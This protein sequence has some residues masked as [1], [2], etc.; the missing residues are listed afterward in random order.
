MRESTVG[1]QRGRCRGRKQKEEE[2]KKKK[3]AEASA[4]SEGR[5][6][7]LVGPTSTA[8]PINARHGKTDGFVLR[9]PH[10]SD[11][12]TP[13]HPCL[14]R[15]TRAT[16]TLAAA[17]EAE[18]PAPTHAFAIAAEEVAMEPLSTATAPAAMEE[19]S[20]SSGGGGGVGERRSR[21]RRICV[22]CGS[23]KG[24]KPSYQDAAVDLGKELVINRLPIH[25]HFDPGVSSSF[26]GREVLI[27]FKF[28]P[29]Y[30]APLL[31]ELND[32]V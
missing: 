18:A 29:K 8:T 9:S 14:G 2:G 30:R 16:M 21:F 26:H 23:A 27:R 13:L 10:T 12:G 19:E 1:L 28:S 25:L 17:A 20:S 4:S 22:Y 32:S 6:K 24:K 15:K 3:R 5:K 31:I 7:G 11:T